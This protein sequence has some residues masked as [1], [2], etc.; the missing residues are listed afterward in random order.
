MSYTFGDHEEASLRLHR[1]A[2][3]YEPETC[4]LLELLCDSGDA[5]MPQLA[6]DLGCGPGWSTQLLAA[7]L[8]PK[9]IVGFD[10]SERYI[11][12]ARLNHPELEFMRHDILHTPFPVGAP[13]LL[14]CRF[15][16]THLTSPQLALQAWAQVAAPHAILL[17]HETEGLESSHTALHRYYELID[18]MQRHYGQVLNVGTILDASFTGTDWS[19]EQS[20]SLILE[21]PARDMAQLHLSNL[22]TW[23]RNEYAAQAFDRRELDELEVA[24][25]SIASG[26][27]EAGVVRNT[28]RQIVAMLR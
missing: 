11:A 23:G 9:R 12:E 22:R 19:V 6:I 1:L 27:S 16:L 2:D 21:K 4:A 15:V 8:K 17:I 7:V 10:A 28:A 24:L 5:P 14:F 18:E 20:R 26:I 13:D 25:E 3:L